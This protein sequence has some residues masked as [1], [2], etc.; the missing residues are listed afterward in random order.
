M[1]HDRKGRRIEIGDYV[2]YTPSGVAPQIGRVSAVYAGQTTC[3]LAVTFYQPFAAPTTTSTTA[4][5]SDL[6]M[7]S[8]G[9]EPAEP[10]VVPEVPGSA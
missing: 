4:K 3:N 8:D 2:R 9:S 5:E 1:P 10:A 6:V 7:K